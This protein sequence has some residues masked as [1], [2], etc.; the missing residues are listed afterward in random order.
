MANL[1]TTTIYGDLTVTGDVRADEIL[2]ATGTSTD[3]NTAGGT[4][5]W[6]TTTISDAPYSFDG[7]TVTIERDGTYE[8]EADADFGNAGTNIRS[9]PNLDVKLNGTTVGVMGRSGYMRNGSGADHSSVHAKAVVEASSGDS[10]VIGTTAESTA[11]TCVPDRAQ[12]YIKR[13]HR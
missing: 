11:N 10:I 6:T 3:I 12:L 13:L 5:A 8:I 4:V 2:V 9:N 7:T 1:S